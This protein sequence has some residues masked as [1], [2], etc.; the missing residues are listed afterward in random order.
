MIDLSTLDLAKQAA[1]GRVFPVLH[2]VS[3]E[4]LKGT[5]GKPVT[6]TLVGPD[7]DQAFRETCEIIDR[8]R[9]AQ[10]RSASERADAGEGPGFE[11]EYRRA[12]EM[13]VRRTVAWEGLALDGKALDC[14]PETVRMVYNRWRWIREQAMGHI[15]DR[16]SFFGD[17]WPGSS[18]GTGNGASGS[19]GTAPSATES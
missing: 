3:H 6:I 2:P 7:S 5:D 4:P 12:T 15:Q 18:T 9:A 16:E 19:T 17:A 13:L 1:E 14:N 11:D 10:M 8:E